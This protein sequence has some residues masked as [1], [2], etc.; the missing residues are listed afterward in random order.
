MPKYNFET[1]AIKSIMASKKL[2]KLFFRKRFRV[3]NVLR[4]HERK[5]LHSHE[6][7]RSHPYVCH[8]KCTAHNLKCKQVTDVSLESK[9][10][11]ITWCCMDRNWVK[12]D[13]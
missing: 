11:F 5:K 2:V 7:K 12:Y 8:W 10:G 13:R 4:K 1:R 6:S 3:Q 9:G